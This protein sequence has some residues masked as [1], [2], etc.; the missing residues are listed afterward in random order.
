MK[1]RTVVAY[2]AAGAAL[3]LVGCS[4][5][6][7]DRDAGAGATSQAANGSE[8]VASDAAAMDDDADD[9]DGDTEAAEDD[10]DAARRGAAAGSSG[11][12]IT[13]TT[14]DAV[15]RDIIYQ[16]EL[17]IVT[18]DIPDATWR[19]GTIASQ[20]GGFVANETTSDD[21]ATITLRIPAEAH[22]DAIGELSALGTVTDRS[23]STQD[24]TQDMVDTKS[25]ISSQ[26]QSIARIRELL[27]DA[28]DLSDVIALEAELASRES[29][30]DALLSRQERLADLTSLATVTVHFSLPDEEVIDDEPDDEDD[31]GFLAGL[32]NGWGAFTDVFG[33]ASTG[34]GA[35]LPFLLFGAA[36]GAPVVVWLRRRQVPTH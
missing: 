13:R 6:N 36:L 20:A 32:A 8:D 28:S 9:T 10:T 27:D 12:V 35:A 1:R 23:R 31:A 34:L 5:G 2:V 7:D 30:L 4:G 15:G 25:R 3:A 19:A 11:G 21:A 29:D 16:V 33:A 18:D 26:R 22:A 17:E 14:T 24:A